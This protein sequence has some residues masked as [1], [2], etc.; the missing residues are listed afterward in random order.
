M[1]CTV[2]MKSVVQLFRVKDMQ[3]L[4]SCVLI[5]SISIADTLKFRSAL[6][7][8]KKSIQQMGEKASEKVFVD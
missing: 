2:S 5:W 8:Q 4:D 6:E 7:S 3:S 1:L